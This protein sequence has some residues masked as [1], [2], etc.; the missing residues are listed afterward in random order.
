MLNNNQRECIAF[1]YK[2][3]LENRYNFD[4]VGGFED[5]RDLF[6]DLAGSDPKL[7]EMLDEVYEELDTDP[8]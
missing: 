5:V 6:I 7:K 4:P 8:D 1:H 3:Y 2:A